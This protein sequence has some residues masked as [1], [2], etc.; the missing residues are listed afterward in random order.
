MTRILS[1]A[2]VDQLL[3]MREV[4]DWMAEAFVSLSRNESI[5]PVR[6]FLKLP[7]NNDGLLVMPAWQPLNSV[8][9][10]AKPD[11]SL[12]RIDLGKS[13]IGGRYA[14]KLISLCKDNPKTDLPFARATV[15]VID[16]KSGALLAV[17][18]GEHLTAIRTGAGSGLATNLL[19]RSDASTVAVVGAGRQAATQL[20]AVCAVRPIDRAFVLSNSPDKGSTFASVM[21]HTLGIPVSWLARAS[22][23][24]G[25]ALRSADVICTATNSSVPVID[26]SEVSPG[27]HINGVGSHR[28][29]MVEVPGDVVV[30]SRVFVDQR[31]ACF[32]EAGDLVEPIRRGI[33]RESDVAGEIGEVVSGEVAGRTSTDEITF[34][35]SVGN[36]VQDLF[37]ASHLVEKAAATG[38]GLLVDMG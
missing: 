36:G 38:I 7:D 20:E 3:E 12:R 23:E 6:S 8:G 13:A 34:F 35:K 16:S 22:A 28:H 11:V 30:A 18:E 26:R 2:D 37:V 9:P 24:S 25:D 4:I 10:S 21:S 27:T 1:R 14:V 32:V 17:I 29:D 31:E 33:L 5:V 19:A 15:L